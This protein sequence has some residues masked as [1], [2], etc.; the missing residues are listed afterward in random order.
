MRIVFPLIV[1]VVLPFALLSCQRS[2]MTGTAAP[3][4]TSASDTELQQYVGRRVSVHGPFSLLGKAGPYILAG[5]RPIYLLSSGPFSWGERYARVEGQE[6]RVTG[7][8]RFAHYPKAPS[9]SIPVDRPADC[10]YFEA[11]SASVELS[12]NGVTKESL[13]AHGFR[14]EEG[15]IYSRRYASLGEASLELDFSLGSL[16]IPPNATDGEPDLRV[17]EVRGLG[18]VVTA[19]GG[20]RLDDPSTPC[21]VSV[22]LVQVPRYPPESAPGTPPALPKDSVFTGRVREKE[23][24][25]EAGTKWAAV[26]IEIDTDDPWL[27][28]IRIIYNPADGV[29]AYAS[30]TWKP[31]PELKGPAAIPALVAAQEGKRCRLVFNAPRWNLETRGTDPITL[32][33]LEWIR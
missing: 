9:D 5:E 2:V 4:V 27:N 33:S 15:S 3:D 20:G 22:S 21:S 16:I 24:S 31:M 8:L 29:V 28:E 12:Q 25:E 17:V 10:F 13:V 14:H 26:R 32:K 18:F 19:E 11:A 30:S 7:I 6:V 1:C 23:E